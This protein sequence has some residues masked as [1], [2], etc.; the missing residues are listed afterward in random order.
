MTNIVGEPVISVRLVPLGSTGFQ[1]Q[2]IETNHEI[3]RVSVNGHFYEFNSK[4]IASQN[5]EAKNVPSCLH[6]SK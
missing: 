6:F 5:F 4:I 3:P 1:I 2:V